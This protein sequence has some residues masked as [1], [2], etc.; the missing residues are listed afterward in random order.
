MKLKNFVKNMIFQLKNILFFLMILKL[1]ACQNNYNAHFFYMPDGKKISATKII[2]FEKI[3]KIDF[4]QYGGYQGKVEIDNISIDFTIHFENENSILVDILTNEKIKDIKQNPI[5]FLSF[6]FEDKNI[7]LSDIVNFLQ[8]RYDNTTLKY[9]VI[10]KGNLVCTYAFI[11]KISQVEIIHLNVYKFGKNNS[12]VI[13]I[14][15]S[16]F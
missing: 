16:N 14:L 9:L 12:Y 2:D 3:Y 13:T 4:I 7:K 1:V 8:K 15:P 5:T 6:T 11:S 10:N